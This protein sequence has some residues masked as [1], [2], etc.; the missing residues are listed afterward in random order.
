ML[1]IGWQ[2][3]KQN[4]KVRKGGC[5]RVEVRFPVLMVGEDE[6]IK[7]NVSSSSVKSFMPTT[8]N[9]A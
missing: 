6:F 8:S 2:H 9:Q 5:R 7:G 3:L 4:V 1:A